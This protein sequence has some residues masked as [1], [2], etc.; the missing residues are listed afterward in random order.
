[1]A[2]TTQR[3]CEQAGNKAA[4][5]NELKVLRS[6]PPFKLF[7][8]QPSVSHLGHTTTPYAVYT[9]AEQRACKRWGDFTEYSL[10]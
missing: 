8:P 1:V 4:P 10:P 2:K 7:T 3:T 5:M 6:K 9:K